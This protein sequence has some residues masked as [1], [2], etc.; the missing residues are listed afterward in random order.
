MGRKR[1]RGRVRIGTSGFSY[2]HWREVFYPAA[3]PERRWLEH[4]AE[5]FDT[6]ELNSTFYHLPKAE[7]FDSWRERTPG[8]FLFV[9]KLSRFIT[10]RKNLVDCGEPLRL[11]LDRAERL[12]ERLGPILVQLPPGLKADAA[13]LDRFLELC[14]RRRRWAVEFRNRSWLSDEIMEVLRT[15]GAALCIHDLIEEHRRDVTADFVYLRFHGSGQK[16]GGSY[17]PRALAAS[18]RE[19]RGWI[20]GGFDVFAYFNNDRQGY[21]VGNAQELRRCVGEGG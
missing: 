17:P 6:V 11:F 16:Y 10:H 20:E 15:H 14:P 2:P 9:L 3:V 5:H 4:Y 18:A 7:T 13:R 8:G 12:G 1:D 21:A 19:I